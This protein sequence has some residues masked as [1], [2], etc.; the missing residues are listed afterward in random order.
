VRDDSPRWEQINPSSFEHEKDGLRELASY[1]PDADPYHVWANIEFVAG[2]GS[3]NEVDALVL[4][5]SGL[6]VLELKHWQGELRGD[7][8]QWVRRAPNSRLIPE[9]NPYVL[10]NRKAKRLSSLIAHYARQ[11]RKT[12]PT[13]YVGAAVFLHAVALT[14]DLDAIGQQHVYGLDGHTESS[15]LPSLRDMLLAQPRNPA[16]RIDS[17]R[18]REIV[19]LVKGA[20][21]RPSVAE[22]KV[23]QLLTYAR[24]MAEGPGWQDF[25]AAHVLDR[26]LLRRVR[27]YLTSR[28]AEEDVPAIRGAAE[29]EFR[30]LQ[31]IHHPGIAAAHDL[32][33]HPWGPAVVFDHEKEWVRLDH[34]LVQRGDRLTMA[35]RLNLLGDLAEIV[36]YAHS[37]RLAHRALHPGAV[38]VADPDASR[39]PLIVTNW[40]TGGR[41]PDSTLLTRSSTSTD[42]ASLELFFDDEVRRYQAPEVATATRPPGHQLDVFSLGAIAHRIFAGEAPVGTAEELATAVRDSGVNLAAAVD[43]MPSALV[44]AVYD[45]TRG[46]PAVRLTSVAKFRAELERVWEELTAPE[47]EPVV[48]PLTARRGDVLESGLTVVSRLGAGS[49]AVALA[50]TESTEVEDAQAVE[51]VLKVARDV[52]HDERLL[53]EART[54]QQLRHPQVVALVKEPLIVGGQRALL[55]ESAGPRALS[56]ELRDGRLGI[57]LLE[58]YGRDL[59]EIVAYLDGQGVWH[60]DLKPANLAA[61]PRPRDKQPHLCVFDFSLSAAPA[62]QIHAGTTGYLDPFLGADYRRPR[63]DAAA[64]RFAAAV[65]LFEMATGTLPQWGGANPAAVSGEVSLDPAMFH[66]GVADRLVDFFGR[67]LARSVS[68]R[69]HTIDEMIDAWRGIFKGVPQ[70]GTTSPEPSLTTR[71]TRETPLDATDLTERAVTAVERLGLISIG[72][73]LDVAPSTLTRAR[74]IP[75]ATRKEILAQAR[76]LRAALAAPV[77]EPPVAEQAEQSVEAL[78][79]T[80]LPED[81][82]RN[83]K[84]RSALAVLLGQ[85][86]GAGDALLRWPTQSEVGRV[87]ELTQPQISTLVRRQLARWLANAGLSAVRDEIAALLDAR[88]SVMSAV[89]LAE[90]LVATHGSFTAEP[91]RTAQAIGVIRAAVEA[92]LSLGGN[93][94]VAI[95]RFRQSDT[96]LVGREPDDN[97]AETTA[98]DLLTYVMGL[99]D[100]AAVLAAAD[101]LPSRQRAADELRMLTA[102]DAM[103]VLTDLRLLQ[104]AAAGSNGRAEVNAQGQLY[105]NGMSAERALRLTAGSLIGQRLTPQAVRDRVRVRFPQA[106]E[107]P[108]RPALTRLLEACGLPLNWHPSEGIYAPPT[109]PSLLTGTRTGTTAGSPLVTMAE[110]GEVA[111]K[112]ASAIDRHAFLAVL[113][114]LKLLTGTRR[115]LLQRLDLFEVDVTAILLERLRSLGYAWETIVAADNGS[116]MDPDF[117]S[118][119]ELVQ[120]EVMPAIREQLATERPV[121]LTEAAPLARY[122]QLQLLQEL[123][124]PTRRRPAARLLLVAARKL[125]PAMLDGVQIPLTSPASQSLW[126]SDT[127]VSGQLV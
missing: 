60:R 22:R 66:Q 91:K 64:E 17:A 78:A 4:T 71:L 33:E 125:E 54:L 44:D 20:K 82:T 6:F 72:D 120:H 65:T 35:Q 53:A 107:L 11:Q 23:G 12:A 47:P 21:I 28:A 83:R 118:L 104:L 100:R 18:A 73:L 98:A 74:N 58:R 39:P 111:D 106:Q 36:D 101:P 69:F 126:I 59:L 52:R 42:P 97:R 43:G 108:A 115:S 109:A 26:S 105:P 40:Q 10:A 55:M 61:R 112:L 30:L 13:P 76:L 75:D 119:T 51:L 31:G 90:A 56:E 86:P 121:L 25:V 63:Y 122:G 124:D 113:T 27:F 8:N 38:Y 127:W 77:A 114:S 80:L 70:A 87:A 32:V 123:A 85:A 29:R 15:G 81:T 49:T 19:D 9:D 116:P 48:D 102:P 88:G 24:P 62:D 117:R 2:D 14:T 45:A 16:H 7:G 3:I 50:V 93:A 68:D 57:D 92:E 41:L 89:E 37:R 67:S 103:P 110:A 5:P 34:W 95:Q 46:D 84:G 94:R 79:G 96:V 99:G 1:L